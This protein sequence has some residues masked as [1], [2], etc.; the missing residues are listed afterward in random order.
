[1]LVGI[2]LAAGTDG[3]LFGCGFAAPSIPWF[4]SVSIS[5]TTL[6]TSS[7]EAFKQRI[8]KLI[9]PHRP[10]RVEPRAIKRKKK[11]YQLLNKPRKQFREIAHRNKYVAGLS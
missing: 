2:A 8:A 1:M 3:F 5:F 9:I 7:T 4:P 6:F 10:D 11:N